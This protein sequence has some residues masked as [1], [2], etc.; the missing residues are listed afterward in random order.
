MRVDAMWPSASRGAI[1]PHDIATCTAASY[2]SIARGGAMASRLSSAAEEPTTVLAEPFP[3]VFP[4]TR[5]RRWVTI[6][7]LALVVMAVYGQTFA[8]I[9]ELYLHGDF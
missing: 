2:H 8:S 5:Y 3:S 9:F 7:G 4:L 1:R 6:V